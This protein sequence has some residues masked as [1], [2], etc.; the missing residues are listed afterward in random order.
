MVRP[1]DARN[2]VSVVVGSAFV[3]KEG[4]ETRLY[5]QSRKYRILNFAQ[6][7]RIRQSNNNIDVSINLR[8]P[9]FFP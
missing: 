1:G 8:M 5:L 6:T 3:L 2:F 7:H 4:L 9:P